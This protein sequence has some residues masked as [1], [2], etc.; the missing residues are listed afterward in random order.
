MPYLDGGGV[1]TIGFGTTVYPNGKRVSMK[2]QEITIDLARKMLDL[3]ATKLWEEI[4]RL[5]RPPLNDNQ[6][7][8]L[9]SF[10][11]NVGLGAFRTSTLLRMINVNPH[12]LKITDQLARWNKDNGKIIRGLVNRRKAEALLYFTAAVLTA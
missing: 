1:P 2:D 7:S 10:A 4:D 9:T 6:M 8:A 3:H 5:V 12:D 11:Y